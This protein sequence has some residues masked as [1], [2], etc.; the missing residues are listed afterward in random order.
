MAQATTSLHSD[1][2]KPAPVTAENVVGRQVP[3]FGNKRTYHAHDVA[4]QRIVGITGAIV[5]EA[6]RDADPGAV[7][8]G[9]GSGSDGL[10]EVGV[11]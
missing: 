3:G 8:S 7:G 9:Q 1:P 6:R 10:G 2:W 4:Y 5:S 11:G